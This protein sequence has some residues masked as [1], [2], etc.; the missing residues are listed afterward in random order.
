MAPHPTSHLYS[1]W[2]YQQ[3]H[4]LHTPSKA[5][6]AASID[7]CCTHAY[8][9]PCTLGYNLTQQNFKVRCTADLLLGHN[10]LGHPTCR[11]EI[12][13]STMLKQLPSMLKHA[14]ATQVLLCVLIIV[15]LE[16]AIV[17]LE[18]WA[19]KKAAIKTE[20]ISHSTSVSWADDCQTAVEWQQ[21]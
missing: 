5:R 4:G 6:T 3:A 20:R 19:G 7:R 11:A 9:L 21:Q 2:L 13:P 16:G 8:Q 10:L 14:I 18:L 1:M 12:C 17:S 15:H